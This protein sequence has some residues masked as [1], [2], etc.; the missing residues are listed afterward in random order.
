M[1]VKDIINQLSQDLQENLIFEAN[2]I[3]V[4]GCKLFKNY[5]SH[6]FKAECLKYV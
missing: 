2:S 6:E 3:I 1:E 4:E 5:F